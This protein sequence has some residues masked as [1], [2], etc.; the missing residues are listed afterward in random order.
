MVPDG[1]ANAIDCGLLPLVMT[2]LVKVERRK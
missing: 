1:Q 2:A